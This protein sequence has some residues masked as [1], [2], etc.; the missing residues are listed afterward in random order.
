MLRFFRRACGRPSSLRS[1]GS[2]AVA[3]KSLGDTILR[4]RLGLDRFFTP[5]AGRRPRR[6]ALVG[7][8]SEH[9]PPLL[10]QPRLRLVGGCPS[11]AIA[12]AVA[13]RYARRHS[14][15]NGRRC[16]CSP[17]GSCAPRPRSARLL[18]RAD[19]AR[20]GLRP[21]RLASSARVVALGT[22]RTYIFLKSN[23]GALARAAAAK[24]KASNGRWPLEV[25]LKT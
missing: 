7:F 17:L 20:V 4:L 10:R 2:A 19:A 23:R 6:R 12:C 3:G 14:F 24:K 5:R 11:P 15:G 25:L 13:A 16:L 22:Q 18:S 8:A 1:E 21:P 9:P